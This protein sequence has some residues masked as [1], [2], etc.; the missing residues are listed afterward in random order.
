LGKSRGQFRGQTG[1]LFEGQIISLQAIETRSFAVS[2]TI[3]TPSLKKAENSGKAEA[4]LEAGHGPS[5]RP[6]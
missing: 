1:P 2:K 4:S 3:I 6:K 5:L